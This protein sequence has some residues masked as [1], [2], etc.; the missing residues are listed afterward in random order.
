MRP[1]SVCKVVSGGGGACTKPPC[2]PN[3]VKH[4]FRAIVKQAFRIIE[5]LCLQVHAPLIRVSVLGL[6]SRS[7]WC[8]LS[9]SDPAETAIGYESVGDLRAVQHVGNFVVVLCQRGWL[10]G[11]LLC[12]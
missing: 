12:D 3:H 5:T 8:S 1:G 7:Q 10:G 9:P 11:I 6:L 4:G 2:D